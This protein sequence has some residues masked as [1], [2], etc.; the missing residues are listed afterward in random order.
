MSHTNREYKN[1]VFKDLFSD[2]ASALDLYNALTDSSFTIDDGLCFT[3]LENALFMGQLN[4][5]SFTIGDK[6]VICIEHQASISPNM[7]IRALMYIGRVKGLSGN[8]LYIFLVFLPDGCVS[9][10]LRTTEYATAPLP[11][12]PAKILR[13]PVKLIPGQTLTRK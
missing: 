5:V 4:D 13:N 11:C 9:V 10:T 8:K 2:E 12:P 1:S 6:L 7:P 3:T